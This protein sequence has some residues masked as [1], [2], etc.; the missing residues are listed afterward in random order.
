MSEPLVG[1]LALQGDFDEHE[2]A[3][4]ALGLRTRQIRRAADLVGLRGIVLPGGESTTML[5]L[6]DVEGL[7]EPLGAALR[8]GL[9]VFA[10]CAGMILLA[11]RVENPQQR[12]Y[13]LLPITVVRNGYGRQLHSGTFAL[14]STVLPAGT[15]GT[16]IRAPRITHVDGG[17]EVLARRGGDPVLVQCGPILAACFHPELALRHPVCAR[18]AAMVREQEAAPAPAA[19]MM[20]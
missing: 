10:T 3:L 5:R 4:Q 1:V 2:V 7:W 17:C 13:A 18:F 15:T 8:S 12:S 6:L 11:A 14:E 9:P 20:A 16:F 19:A